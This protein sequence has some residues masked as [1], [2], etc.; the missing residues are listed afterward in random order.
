MPSY[1]RRSSNKLKTC[2]PDLQRLFN[3]VVKH[4]DCTIICGHRSEEEQ[5]DAYYS[6]RSRLRYPESKHNKQP[7]LALDVAPYPINW[8]DKERFYYFA[9]V[10]KGIA[11]QMNIPIRWGG[12]WDTDTDV[13]D[14]TF[15]DLPHFELL[16]S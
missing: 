3:E 5:S 6:G 2:H 11:T 12:D 4:F 8:N 14:Q 10:V 7:S 1:S 16:K 13:H 15:F 9:G